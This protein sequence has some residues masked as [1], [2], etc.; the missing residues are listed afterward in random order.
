LNTHWADVHRQCHGGKTTDANWKQSW[1][2]V[3]KNSEK[4]WMEEKN[5]R[6]FQY[7]VR[8]RFGNIWIWILLWLHVKVKSRAA[9]Q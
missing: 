5:Q 9:A 6:Y 7:L 4:W 2:S 3:K 1:T 8:F